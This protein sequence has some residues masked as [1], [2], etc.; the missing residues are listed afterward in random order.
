MTKKRRLIDR[1]IRIKQKELYLNIN[2]CK[3][4]CLED[5]KSTTAWNQ[6]WEHIS[7]ENKHF[8][9]SNKRY[10]YWNDIWK[11]SYNFI[12]YPKKHLSYTKDGLFKKMPH[13]NDHY[14]KHHK[15]I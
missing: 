15:N 9:N 11:L 13:P 2:R 6:M 5:G 10:R 12:M 7:L 3:I 14:H 1:Y 4:L 8:T